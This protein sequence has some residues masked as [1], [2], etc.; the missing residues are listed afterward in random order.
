MGGSCFLLWCCMRTYSDFNTGVAY[1]S[2]ETLSKKLRQTPKSTHNQLK[3][4]IEG[5]YVEKKQSGGKNFYRIIDKFK[6]TEMITDDEDTELDSA[7]VPEL[8][9]KRMSALKKFR[10]SEITPDEL[11]ALGVNVSIPQTVVNNFFIKGNNN[12]ITNNQVI[13]QKQETPEQDSE[14]VL[15]QLVHQRDNSTNA[16]ERQSAERWIEIIRKQIQDAED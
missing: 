2:V 16:L 3:K 5:G 13:I 6:A 14:A 7:Y 1:P 10:S 9:T 15:R 11:R 12:K 8:F 4:L